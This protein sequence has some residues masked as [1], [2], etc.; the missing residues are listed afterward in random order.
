MNKLDLNSY[1]KENKLELYIVP[2]AKENSIEFDKD[3]GL[4]AKIKAPPRENLANEE[5]LKYLKK[6]YGLKVSLLKGQKSRL[7]VFSVQ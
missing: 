5:I 1:I 2:N 6:E 4:I 3:R 7:K